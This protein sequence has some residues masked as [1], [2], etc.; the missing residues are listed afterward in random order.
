MFPD[1]EHIEISDLIPKLGQHMLS[2]SKS[3]FNRNGEKIV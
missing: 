2:I 1:E 3:I